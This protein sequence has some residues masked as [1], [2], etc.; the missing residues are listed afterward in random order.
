MAFSATTTTRF[1]EEGR[2][3]IIVTLRFKAFNL[4]R[5][6]RLGISSL[7]GFECKVVGY[8]LARRAALAT[9]WIVVLLYHS[10]GMSAW[11]VVVLQM[12]AGTGSCQKFNN[13]PLSLE[14]EY[15]SVHCINKLNTAMV[16]KKHGLLK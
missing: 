10:D 16:A 1:F 5:E 12:P 15:R 7:K 4:D 9:C 11:D 13:I 2:S 14:G 3:A 6:H 8:K